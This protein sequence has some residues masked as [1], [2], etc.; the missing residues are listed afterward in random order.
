M[1]LVHAT[2]VAL[3]IATDND[4]VKRV[5][6]DAA[7]AKRSSHILRRAGHARHLTDLEE[8]ASMKIKRDLNPADVGTHYSSAA[9]IKLFESH[10][11]GAPTT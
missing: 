2:C 6:A 3:G 1:G 8:I 10:F 9:I 7:S 11:R 5:M 4:A